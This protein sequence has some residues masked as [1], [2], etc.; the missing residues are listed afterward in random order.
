MACD[1]QALLTQANC[2]QCL[3]AG[4]QQLARL[5][6]LCNLMQGTNISCDPAA[7]LAA[8]SCFSCASPGERDLIELV[9]LCQIMSGT[10]I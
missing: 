3:S 4:E 7:L 6:I 10:V 9:L 5:V 2:F 1:V 8:S